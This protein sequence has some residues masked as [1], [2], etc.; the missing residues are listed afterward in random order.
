MASLAGLSLSSAP[1]AAGLVSMK[2]EITGRPG[3]YRELEHLHNS[4][5]LVDEQLTG[6]SAARDRR[7]RR[8]AVARG[9]I[10]GEVRRSKVSAWVLAAQV[11]RSQVRPLPRSPLGAPTRS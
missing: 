4:A 2:T 1:V 6:S 3:D 9:A 10:R 7:P 5:V 8:R 11:G